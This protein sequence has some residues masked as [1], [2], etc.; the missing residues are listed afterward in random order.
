MQAN[1]I[2]QK[3][4][5]EQDYLE[6]YPVEHIPKGE[7]TSMELLWYPCLK[8][9]SRC[10]EKAAYRKAKHCKSCHAEYRNVRKKEKEL[11]S[12]N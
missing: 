1:K 5:K 9:G 11:R 6:A 12:T 10:W 3:A 7:E 2:K 8:D 4:G